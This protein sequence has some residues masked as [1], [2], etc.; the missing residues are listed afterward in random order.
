MTVVLVHGAP[1]TDAVWEPLLGELARL[2]KTD[3]VR[4]SPP[5]FGA[6]LPAEFGATI[7]DYRAWL[8]GELSKLDAP[9]DLVGHDWGGGH[10]VGVAMTRPDL[11]RSWVS[12]IVGAFEPDYVWHL[13]AQIWQKP[14][15]GEQNLAEL[16][17]GS[18]DDRTSRNH[19]M[20]MPGPA[21]R[22][23]AKGQGPA[24][25]K[26]MLA[27]YRS[28]AQPVLAEIGKDLSAAAARPGLAI[29][30]TED[31]AVGSLKQ[32]HHGAERAGA[33]IHVLE[34]LGHWWMLQDPAQGARMLSAFLGRV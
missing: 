19:E 14:G 3:V 1:E 7:W 25:A 17:G 16:F 26:A 28:T 2:G 20:G 5:G 13:A 11:I 24:M 21:A 22:E 6:P 33:Q 31:D 12:D 34:G 23:I 9:V 30:A 15:E 4:L 18:I 8:V 29:V 32:K 10:V 27:L